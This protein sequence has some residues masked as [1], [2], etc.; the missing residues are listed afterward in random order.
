M[1]WARARKLAYLSLHWCQSAMELVQVMLRWCV[2]YSCQIIMVFPPSSPL[3]WELGA[4][5]SWTHCILSWATSLSNLSPCG[6]EDCEWVAVSGLQLTKI[7]LFPVTMTPFVQWNWGG[8]IR[9]ATLSS[10]WWISTVCLNL[11]SALWL[12]ASG[13]GECCWS[14]CRG[15]E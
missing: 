14:W 11:G 12:I 10:W 2:N 5:Q 13:V 8:V 3:S 4:H 9:R 6:T 1:S 15:Q 7:P